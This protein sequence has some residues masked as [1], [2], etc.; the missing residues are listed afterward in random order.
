MLDNLDQIEREA[1]SS[2]ESVQ[3]EDALQSWKVANLG[4]SSPLMGTFDQLREVSKEE[5]PAI[6]RRAN[7]VK[8]A[9]E[10]AYQ[11]REDALRRAAIQTVL[12]SDRLDITLPG[13]PLA[14]GRLHP[15]TQTMREMYSVLADMGFQV[16]RSRE[17]ES[18]EFNFQLLNFPLHHPAR[19]M[20]ELVL[21][22]Y[23]Y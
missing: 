11:A 13:R 14:Y 17:V 3:D 6:G 4:R 18:D 7:E 9:L 2:L 15:S 21:Y 20:Q 22:R 5:R 8:Q 19:E 10:S 16:Y 1:L 12:E 23:R